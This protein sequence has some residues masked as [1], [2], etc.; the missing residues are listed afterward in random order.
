MRVLALALASFFALT[1]CDDGGKT[2][3]KEGIPPIPAQ[4][5]PGL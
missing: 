1:A 3:G 4:M 2:G 5:G